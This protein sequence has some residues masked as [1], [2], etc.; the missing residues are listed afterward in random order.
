MVAVRISI[1]GNYV[2]TSRPLIA[3]KIIQANDLTTLSGDLSTLPAGIVSDPA[4]A[5]GKTL[6]NSLG[7]GQILRS[8]QLQAPW[9]IHQ[10]QSVQVTFRGTGFAASS[11]GK[12]INNAAEGQVV[13][14]RLGS[15]QT[16]SGLATA[17][18]SVEISF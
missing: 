6:R 12:A 10:G 3:G 16:I 15:G 2:T 5:I 7:T 13:Q 4:N 18:G 8:N 1:T 14:V 11:E 17:E 9:V